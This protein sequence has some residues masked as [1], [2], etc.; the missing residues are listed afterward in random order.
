MATN[1]PTIFLFFEILVCPFGQMWAKVGK[2]K[3]DVPPRL[4]NHHQG[5]GSDG[6][7]VF[8]MP[9]VFY[10]GGIFYGALTLIIVTLTLIITSNW[11]LEVCSRAQALDT[12]IRESEIPDLTFQDVSIIGRRQPVNSRTN[13]ITPKYEITGTR[14]FEFTE[15]MEIFFGIPGRIFTAVAI[16]V[17]LLVTLTAYSTIF[18][19]TWALVIPYNNSIPALGSCNLTDFNRLLPEGDCLNSYRFSIGIFACIVLPMCLMNMQTMKPFQ[20]TLS[21][22]MQ[23]TILVAII[24]CVYGIATD[25]VA[26]DDTGPHPSNFFTFD[27]KNFLAMVPIVVYA[28]VLHEGI[29][30]IAQPASNKKKLHKL[31]GGALCFA[32]T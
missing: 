23:F 15:L 20:I 13:L 29:P 28:Q 4:S 1:L 18:G 3:G 19:S 16:I 10:H 26:H 31:F 12:V 7:L 17:Y 22:T 6:G 25:H 2:I 11:T 9:Y 14:K 32:C 21:F 27:F 8:S 5:G 30:M 24:H